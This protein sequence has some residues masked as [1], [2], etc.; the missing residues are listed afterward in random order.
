MNTI[1]K[2]LVGE[3]EGNKE[4][5]PDSI[6]WIGTYG[7]PLHLTAGDQSILNSSDGETPQYSPSSG[8]HGKYVCH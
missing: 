1:L 3:K 5:K 7:F 2:H 6:V 8:E 4:H